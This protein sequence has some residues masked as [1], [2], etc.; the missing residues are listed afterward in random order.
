MAASSQ[1]VS[2]CDKTCQGK[3]KVG[4]EKDLADDLLTGIGRCGSS[5][6]DD[7]ILSP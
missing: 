7:L 6:D 4:C 1:R 3:K 5:N 2:S